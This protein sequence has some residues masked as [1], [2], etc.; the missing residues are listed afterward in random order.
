MSRTS[1]TSGW[2]NESGLTYTVCKMQHTTLSCR[3]YI[4]N[5]SLLWRIHSSFFVL[6]LWR[7]DKLVS[8][9]EGKAFPALLI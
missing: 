8:T 3:I 6:A 5:G 4:E 9:L 7:A 2:V 1:R